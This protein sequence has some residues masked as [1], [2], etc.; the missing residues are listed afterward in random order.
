MPQLRW[1]EPPEEIALHLMAGR[2]ISFAVEYRRLWRWRRIDVVLFP[3]REALPLGRLPRPF[4]DTP[5]THWIVWQS[6]NWRGAPTALPCDA[7]ALAQ[8]LWLSP[9]I[10]GE[11]AVIEALREVVEASWR[12]GG[13]P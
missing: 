10:P 8:R 7:A 1:S 5:E 3:L 11:A 9:K 4:A 2:G 12:Q 6:A 13:I